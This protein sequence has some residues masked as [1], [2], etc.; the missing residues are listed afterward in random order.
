[1]YTIIA[2]TYKYIDSIKWILYQMI[3][4]NENENSGVVVLINDLVT[5]E[6]VVFREPRNKFSLI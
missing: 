6:L 2:A 5:K 3:F 4:N 1:M